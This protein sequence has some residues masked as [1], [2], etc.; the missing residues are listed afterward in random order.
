VPLTISPDTVTFPAY[1]ARLFDSRLAEYLREPGREAAA[2]R[3]RC[4]FQLLSDREA[5]AHVLE[6]QIFAADLRLS[7]L[8]A[9]E[10]AARTPIGR[11]PDPQTIKRIENEIAAMRDEVSRLRARRSS[12]STRSLELRF[13]A[14]RTLVIRSLSGGARLK[15]LPPAS[16]PRG[17]T[18]DTVREKIAQLQA[19]LKAVDDAPYPAGFVREKAARFIEQL[20]RPINVRDAIENGE[21]PY[22]PLMALSEHITAPDALGI[23]V[24]ALGPRIMELVNKEIAECSD[25]KHALSPE[26]RVARTA[27]IKTDLLAAERV[28]ALIEWEALQEGANLPLRAEADP[29]AI[30]GVE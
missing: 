14:C 2:R 25:E 30:I 27:K 23:L 9:D 4:E 17:A 19:D 6:Q 18:L 12:I 7:S 10:S 20:A 5:A 26:Q 21:E 13:N 28:E 1:Q 22:L 3:L 8:Y 16:I 11:K 15:F 29:R 24:W